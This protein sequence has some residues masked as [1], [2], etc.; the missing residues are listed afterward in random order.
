MKKQLLVLSALFVV[1]ATQCSFYDRMKTSAQ[2]KYASAKTSFANVKT[3]ADKYL[4]GAKEMVNSNL[5]AIKNAMKDPVAK[6]LETAMKL[7]SEKARDAGVPESII[8]KGQ[9]VVKQGFVDQF[10]TTPKDLDT[11]EELVK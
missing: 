5:P 11:G 3:S 6:Y 2:E 9:E 7:A 1:S 10:G 4:P 8:D